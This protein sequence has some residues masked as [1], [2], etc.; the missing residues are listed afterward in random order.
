MRRL[1]G[2]GANTILELGMGDDQVGEGCEG[3]HTSP[4]VFVDGWLGCDLHI[5]VLQ[6]SPEGHVITTSLI[7]RHQLCVT[8]HVCDC[9]LSKSDP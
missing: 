5:E 1:E 8:P 7:H 3:L 2:L 4:R 9:W 6:P